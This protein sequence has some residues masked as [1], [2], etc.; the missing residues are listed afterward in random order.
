MPQHLQELMGDFCVS[1]WV[2]YIDRDMFLVILL[3]TSWI[4]LK[5]LRLHHIL[6][7]CIHSKNKT[8]ALNY[9]FILEQGING[10]IE[11][12]HKGINVTSISSN[13]GYSRE[14]IRNSGVYV[15][16]RSRSYRMLSKI[17]RSQE[18]QSLY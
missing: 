12:T 1:Y 9:F 17:D 11:F 8:L 5:N 7:W 15:N 14:G 3:L 16:C 6:R 10:S 4:F 13:P 18:H 2:K